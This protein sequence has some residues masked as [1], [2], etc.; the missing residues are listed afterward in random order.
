MVF[1]NWGDIAFSGDGKILCVIGNEKIAVLNFYN[2]QILKISE[3]DK[4]FIQKQLSYTQKELR[5]IH[6]LRLNYEGSIVYAITSRHLV[7]VDL[8]TENI[9]NTYLHLI[10]FTDANFT[11][12]KGISKEIAEQLYKNG[13]I[14]DLDY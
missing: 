3:I 4:I 9:I 6:K 2:K 11:G 8:S 7:A 14:V 5:P 10:D 1:E 12:A 13:G